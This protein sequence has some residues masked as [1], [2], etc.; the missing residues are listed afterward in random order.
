MKLLILVFCI[1]SLQTS[2][3]FS[4]SNGT[5]RIASYNIR[6]FDYDV[7]SSTPTNKLK[8]VE[9]LNELNADIL[10]IQEIN[11]DSEFARMVQVNFNG[12]TKL[13]CL[14]VVVHMTKNLDSS[15]IQKN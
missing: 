11:N 6:N 7:R 2:I 3:A 8:L 9:T 4:K 1:L 13:Y 14:S 10:A 5:L 15:I 12:N